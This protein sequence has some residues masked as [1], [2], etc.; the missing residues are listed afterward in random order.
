MT[1]W[2]GTWQIPKR[3]LYGSTTR[4]GGALRGPCETWSRARALGGIPGH[5]AGNGGPR[6]LRNCEMP[7]GLPNLKI[8]E[9]KQIILASRL[10]MFT[11][12]L[13]LE[14][15]VTRDSCCLSIQPAQTASLRPGYLGSGSSI[16]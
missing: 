9:L 2:R 16:S 10:L 5:S 4:G 14:L 11:I 3:K 12:S 6:L 15:L 13:C 7:E 1:M 8:P